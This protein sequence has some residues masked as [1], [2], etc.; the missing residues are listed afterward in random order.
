[1]V[2]CI[3]HDKNNYFELILNDTEVA[4]KWLY[5]FMVNLRNES[6]GTYLNKTCKYTGGTKMRQSDKVHYIK[7]INE[8]IE[9]VNK[10][11]KGDKFPH[12]AYYGM[13]WEHSQRIHRAFTTS[14]LSQ[15]SFEYRIS[16]RKRRD[17]K[18]WTAKE[19]HTQAPLYVK[20][21]F[22]IIDKDKFDLYSGKI[23]HYIHN[24]EPAI[25][26]Q[27]S[28]DMQEQYGQSNWLYYYWANEDKVLEDAGIAPPNR[29]FIEFT[30]ED[31]E[32]SANDPEWFDCDVFAH[33]NIFG[34]PYLE[35]YLEY[36]DP[37]EIDVKNNSS[38]SGEFFIIDGPHYN[39]KKLFNNSVF[40]K[41]CDSYDLSRAIT[42]PIPI[43]KIG[44]IVY[45]GKKVDRQFASEFHNLFITKK[46]IQIEFKYH[47]KEPIEFNYKY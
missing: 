28:D 27:R 32:E 21:T 14:Q 16:E 46:P 15:K 44:N 2:V 43:G 4:R 3:Q 7:V 13:D 41:W 26:S 29:R 11:I 19:L 5:V 22:D 1:M 12:K 9:E 47:R 8:S 35:T 42:H 37:L 40:S 30:K 31:I 6:L 17:I 24:H 23:N 33:S 20:K 25:P 38:N 39:R 34:K 45:E 36:D 10:S 18:K